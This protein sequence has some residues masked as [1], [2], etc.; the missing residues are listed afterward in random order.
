MSTPSS[1]TPRVVAVVGPLGSGKTSL[2]EALLFACRAIPK[3]GSVRTKDMVGDSSPEARARGMGV[4]TNL[5]SAEFA[6]ERWT[7]VDC[8]GSPEFA[9]ETRHAL[10][11]ADV[12]VVVVD[13]DP[14]RALAAAPVLQA[15]DAARVPHVVFVNKVDR[16]G[17]GAV[18]KDT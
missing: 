16:P 3:K 4:D 6:G 13:P 15:L 10:R 5:A 9:Q 14:S 1:V 18:L 7:F 17:A 8:A 2:L 12:A 11:I